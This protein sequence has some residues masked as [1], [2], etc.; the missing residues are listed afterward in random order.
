MF[1]TY[2]RAETHVGAR[3]KRPER[4][5]HT[6]GTGFELPQGTQIEMYFDA[7][8]VLSLSKVALHFLPA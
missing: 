2:L 4:G 5:L 1:S 8:D 7:D 6:S 3:L